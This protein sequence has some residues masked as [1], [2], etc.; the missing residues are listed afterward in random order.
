M[1]RIDIRCSFCGKT[2]QQVRG[3]LVAGPGVS[4]CAGCV[5]LCTQVLKD[6]VSKTPRDEH[7]DVWALIREMQDQR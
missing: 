3:R 6:D 2:K 4:I 7:Q 1:R 5:E